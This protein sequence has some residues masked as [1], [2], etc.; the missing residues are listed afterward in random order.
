MNV[1]DASTC[2]PI[3]KTAELALTVFP[4]RENKTAQTNGNGLATFKDCAMSKSKLTVDSEGFCPTV[5]NVQIDQAGTNSE[6]I[7]L[8]PVK[9][10][11]IPMNPDA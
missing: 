11:K 7:D 5:E 4:T 6:V 10:K 8:R 2:D 3:T 1:R 9:S